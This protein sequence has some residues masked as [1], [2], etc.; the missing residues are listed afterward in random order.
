M[1][2]EIPKELLIAT[3]NRGKVIE[4]ETLLSELPLKP[5]DLSEFTTI[6]L[7]AETGTSFEENAILKAEG[8]AA[9]TRLWTLADDS[10]LE[11]E[12]L[13]GAPGILSARY[14]GEDASD[15]ERNRKLLYELAKAGDVARRARFVCAIALS[16]PSA[17]T[18]HLSLGTCEGTIS[19]EMRGRHGF[20]YDS[21]FI[22]DGYEQTFG[23]LPSEIKERISH[24]AHAL[25]S[26]RTFLEKHFRPPCLT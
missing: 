5:R 22:P 26:A 4:I 10:G 20:G 15:S 7:I 25:R 24:R 17:K 12:A 18:S 21:V 16:D 1:N 23:E 19:Y 14:A 13:G 11:V 9:Q 3:F 8:Y 6:E 2:P